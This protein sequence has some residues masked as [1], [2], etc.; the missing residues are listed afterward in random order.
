MQELREALDFLEGVTRGLRSKLENLRPPK[1]RRVQKE[2]SILSCCQTTPADRTKAA[3]GKLEKSFSS[4]RWPQLA[5]LRN[6]LAS[7]AQLPGLQNYS[8]PAQRVIAAALQL[9]SRNAHI[10][11]IRNLVIADVIDTY[12]NDTGSVRTQLQPALKHL[13]GALYSEHR[14]SLNRW[15]KAGEWLTEYFQRIPLGAIFLMDQQ[16]IV[17]VMH[18]HPV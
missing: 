4:D 3:F 5:E 16:T 6:L 1:K 18:G 2:Y 13:A 15:R 8:L 7:P 10:S 12:I 14:E 9:E 11:R 17:Y